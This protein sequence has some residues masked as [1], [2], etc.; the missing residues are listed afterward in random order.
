MKSRSPLWKP[1]RRKCD[2]DVPGRSRL[3]RLAT[4]LKTVASA[5]LGRT[6]AGRSLTVFPDDIFLV[7]YFRSGCTWSRFLFG[8]FIHPDD[9]VT[10]ANVARLV[11]T[12]Y[13]HPDRIL[14]TLPRFLQ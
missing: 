5:A 13:K 12:I 1:T 10:F 4:H 9:S 7:G 8:N 11:P 3:S 2:G 14:R 6:P